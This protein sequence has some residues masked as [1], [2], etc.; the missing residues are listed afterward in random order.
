M[1]GGKVGF[2]PLWRGVGLQHTRGLLGPLGNRWSIKR[3]PNGTKLDRWS[4]GT[5][6]RPHGKSLSNP[7]TFN[8]RRWK[9]VEKNTGWHR[10]AGLQNGQREKC[11]DAW[12]EHV[13]KWNAHDDMICNAWHASN[14]K[15]TTANNCT[16]PG[17]SVSGRYNTPPLREDLVPRSRMA[18]EGQRKR[19]RRGKTKLLLWQT[20][21][22]KEP[23]KG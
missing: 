19:K 12:H 10:S 2:G 14:D 4:T 11:S 8:T 6:P 21:E 23:W 17:T 7:K 20:S 3:S 18:P 9:E 1:E 15:A 13:C 22:T 16:T 5:K